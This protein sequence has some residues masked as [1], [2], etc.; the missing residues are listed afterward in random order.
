MLTLSGKMGGRKTAGERG[1]TE[2]GEVVGGRR[3]GDTAMGTRVGSML[4]T[5]Q[6][7]ASS[8][9]LFCFHMAFNPAMWTTKQMLMTSLTA[10]SPLESSESLMSCGE[11]F[12]EDGRHRNKKKKTKAVRKVQCE[13]ITKKISRNNSIKQQSLW[14]KCCLNDPFH[15]KYEKINLSFNYLESIF[16]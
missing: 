5:L 4:H 6:L 14:G 7:L 12:C 13:E 10:A 15:N 11:T 16:E 9:L 1:V 2:V 8:V 3:G